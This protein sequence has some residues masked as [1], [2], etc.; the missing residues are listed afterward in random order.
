MEQWPVQL[1][2][3]LGV[4]IGALASF[5]TTRLVDRSRWQREKAL[6]WDTKRL[7]SYGEFASALR[8]F[9][10]IGYRISAGRGLPAS[11]HPLDTTT[12][13]PALATVPAILENP[14]SRSLKFPSWLS[15]QRVVAE[16]S[17]CWAW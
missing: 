16:I 3:L 8:E 2:T 17:C 4:T 6:R 11:A 13:L 10:T 9:I 1:I 15:A 14:Q 7:E 12:G 5:V